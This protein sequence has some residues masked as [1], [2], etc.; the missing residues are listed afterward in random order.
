MK[1]LKNKVYEYI[2]NELKEPITVRQLAKRIGISELTALKWVDILE[3]EGKI[4]VQKIGGLKI[5]HPI[6][7]GEN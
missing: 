7:E 2:K 1:S 4:K 6:K 3:L 5:V